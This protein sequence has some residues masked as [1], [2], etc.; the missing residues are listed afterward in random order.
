MTA[1]DLWN[2]AL[3]GIGHDRFVSS[4]DS[5]FIE[6]VHCRREWD[7]ARLSVLTAHEWGWL[8]VEAAMCDGSSCF[9]DA[10][11][12]TIYYYPRPPEAILITSVT[13]EDGRRVRF[14]AVNNQIEAPAEPAKIG[15]LVDNEVIDEW[16]SAI[17]DAVVAEL[18]ARIVFPLKKDAALLKQTRVLAAAALATAKQKDSS[19]VTYGGTNGRK[20]ADART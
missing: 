8:V 16:P 6:A 13:D 9:C 3:A 11:G 18:A 14:S 1:V 17:Q 15:Y 19:E 4:E 5:V 2:K 7:G 12:K 20:Y 10:T